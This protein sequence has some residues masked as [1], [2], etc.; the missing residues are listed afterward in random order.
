VQC[1]A[2][3]TP[4]LGKTTAVLP[5]RESYKAENWY[6]R[7][8]GPQDTVVTMRKILVHLASHK[9]HSSRKRAS[10]AKLSK[11][12]RE[13]CD[14]S[15]R[16]SLIELITVFHDCSEANLVEYVKYKINDFISFDLRIF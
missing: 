13:R 10:R 12:Y 8:N 3:R 5:V 1:T 16:G 2:D 9:K 6:N 7:L 14:V 15:H 4:I 11:A